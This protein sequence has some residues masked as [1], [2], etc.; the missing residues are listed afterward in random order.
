MHILFGVRDLATAK[1]WIQ[2]EGIAEITTDAEERH[3]FQ[4]EM[5]EHINTS[6]FSFI[7][8]LEG[9]IEAIWKAGLG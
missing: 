1:E 4:Y 9:G 6:Y 3:A 5:L 8:D 7:L 2:L